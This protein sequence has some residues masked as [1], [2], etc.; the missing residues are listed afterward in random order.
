MFMSKNSTKLEALNEI[1]MENGISRDGTVKRLEIQHFQRAYID[2]LEFEAGD[3]D[4]QN[5]LC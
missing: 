1:F 5:T 2:K 4:D 3:T